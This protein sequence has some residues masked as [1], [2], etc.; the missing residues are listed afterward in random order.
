MDTWEVVLILVLLT[1]SIAAIAKRDLPVSL[2]NVLDNLYFQLAIL[3]LTLGVALVSPA[4]AIV[5]I[6]TI[7]IVY[8]IR[9][10][11][12]VEIAQEMRRME[13]DNEALLTQQRIADLEKNQEPRIEIRE[14]TKIVTELVANKDTIEAALREH[15]TRQTEDSQAQI[16]SRSSIGGVPPTKQVEKEEHNEIP[17]PRGPQKGVESFDAKGNLNSA[18]PEGKN[19][20]P[21]MP[22]DSQ[23]FVSAYNPINGFNESKAAVATLRSYNENAGQFDLHE[24]RP[25]GQVDR[26]EVADF[27]PLKDS[28]VNNFEPI[29][30]SIDDKINTLSRGVLPSTAAP[31]DFDKVIPSKAH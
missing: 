15:E 30:Q 23:V 8:Y 5:A 29:G 6:S 13:R 2:I 7:V 21:L 9:N 4:V 19:R 28:G 22:I 11:V 17:D 26:Y 3:G 25:K 1:V 18:A 20:R 27:L 14:E 16:G 31:P 12:K 10:L 24:S